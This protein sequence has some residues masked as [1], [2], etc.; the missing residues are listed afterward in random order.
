[1]L[2]SVVPML[3][4]D[5]AVRLFP[6]VWKLLSFSRLPSR[7]RAPSL[8][9]FVFYIF[10][11]PPFEDN[12]LL[13]WVRDVLCQNSEVVLWNLF[14]VQMFFWWICGAESDLPVL[15]LNHLRTASR[16]I[17]YFVFKVLIWSND[18]TYKQSNKQLIYVCVC[19][20]VCRAQEIDI[21]LSYKFGNHELISNSWRYRS[22]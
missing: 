12:G 14:G 17:L 9:L 16:E 20:C 21:G 3:T 15:F 4:T 10:F 18:E 6:S 1:M 19:V 11:L 2:P 7:D 13:F 22:R 8:P 5:L